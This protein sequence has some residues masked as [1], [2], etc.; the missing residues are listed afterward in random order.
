MALGRLKQRAASLDAL[1]CADTLLPEEDEI[2]IAKK[3]RLQLKN[4]QTVVLPKDFTD[5]WKPEATALDSLESTDSLLPEDD[6]ISVIKKHHLHRGNRQAAAP[7]KNFADILDEDRPSSGD[8]GISSD[9]QSGSQQR[10]SVSQ[11]TRQTS[12]KVAD[13]RRA[14]SPTHLT[15]QANKAGL[16]QEI[17]PETLIAVDLSKSRHELNIRN[18]PPKSTQ[19]LLKI[20]LETNHDNK[21]NGIELEHVQYQKSQKTSRKGWET[22][23]LRA[24]AVRKVQGHTDRSKPSTVKDEDDANIRNSESPESL[25]SLRLRRIEANARERSRVHTIGAAFDALRQAVPSN[26]DQQKLSKLAVLRI[27]AAYIRSVFIIHLIAFFPYKKDKFSHMIVSTMTY[28]D[29]L[30]SI[31]VT[32]SK[33]TIFSVKVF[34]C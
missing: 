14:I 22:N 15:C 2:N 26:C 8:S 4:K 6:G 10:L 11:I 25:D 29:W 5:R 32:V 7:P 20:K 13:E 18:Q 12:T 27:A 19:K 23:V 16:R 31:Y 33:F 3:A 21:E 9:H 28:V 34:Q 17:E 1:E 24:L 30:T